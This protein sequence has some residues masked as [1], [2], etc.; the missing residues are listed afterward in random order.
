[1]IK[2]IR[3]SFKIFPKLK[4]K[5]K[6]VIY[7]HKKIKET[8]IFFLVKVLKWDSKGNLYTILKLLENRS[9]NLN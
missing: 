7:S 1:M 6:N 8:I 9:S 2:I 3:K 4:K 5:K